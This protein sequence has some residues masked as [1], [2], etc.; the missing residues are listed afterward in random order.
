MPAFFI[1]CS[2]SDLNK[3]TLKVVNTHTQCQQ[4]V[5]FPL[6]PP[7]QTTRTQ[8]QVNRS[9][10]GF[11]VCS[12]TLISTWDSHSPITMVVNMYN[13]SIVTTIVSMQLYTQLSLITILTYNVTLSCYNCTYT[14]HRGL[15]HLSQFSWLQS[16]TT[17]LVLESIIVKVD[18]GIQG[19]IYINAKAYYKSVCNIYLVLHHNQSEKQEGMYVIS[20]TISS[21]KLTMYLH[22]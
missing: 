12:Y 6:S 10:F 14:V 11:S 20:V 5:P 18:I 2:N 16:E 17:T 21:L 22:T 7:L 15:I 9:T 19:V 13:V 4:I 1:C 3:D 8:Q